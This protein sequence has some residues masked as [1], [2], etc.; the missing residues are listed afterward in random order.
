LP[1]LIAALVILQEGHVPLSE[2]RSSV[3]GAL[4]QPQFLP[5]KFLSHAVDHNGDGRRDIWGSV[6][7]TLASI[8]HYLRQ[9]G[10]QPG[11]PWGTE[12]ALPAGVSCA[13]EGPEQG[14]PLGRWQ[15]ANVARIDGGPLAGAPEATRHLMMP[16]GRAGPAFIVSWNFYVL[17]TYNES[18]LY[19]LFVGHLADR[20]RGGGAIRGDWQTVSG[21]SRGEVRA[22]QLRLVEMGY[23]V[24]GADG[25]V[26]FKTRTA[27]GLWQA[28]T[29]L[30]PTCYPDRAVIEALR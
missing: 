8:G 20:L 7:D 22:M 3:A 5:T 14:R 11:E 6:P 16:A 21:I 4:G 2:F 17:K 9:H 13:L 10:W 29:G 23:D 18:D 12:V 25:L 24:G 28:R 1:E 30:T 15:A 26:G 19:A 27:I